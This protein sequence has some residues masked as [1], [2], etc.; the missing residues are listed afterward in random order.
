MRTNSPSPPV[1]HALLALGSAAPTQ[2][3]IA[4]AALVSRRTVTNVIS[5]LRRA[6]VL[7]DD[8]QPVLG[9]GLGLVVGIAIGRHSIRGAA[10]D[11]NG[12]LYHE[13]ETWNPGAPLT[14]LSPGK[15]I[16]DVCGVVRDVL[17]RAVDDQRL[18]QGGRCRLIGIAVAWPA[19][20]DRNARLAGK[21]FRNSAWIRRPRNANSP[22][23]LND[24]IANG[25]GTVVGPQ[26]CHSLNDSNAYAMSLAFDHARNR[27]HEGPDPQWRVL[28]TIRLGG[29]LGGATFTLGPHDS[30]RLGF[31]DGRLI[32]GTN[33]FAGEFGHVPIDRLAVE[34]RDRE[35]PFNDLADMSRVNHQCSCGAS[36]HLEGYA[37]GTALVSRLE[38]SG[39]TFDDADRRRA[40]GL[41]NEFADHLDEVQAHAMVDAGRLIGVGLAGPVVMLDPYEITI[42]GS[43]ATSHVRDGVLLERDR[44]RHAIGDRLA[45]H[46]LDGDAGAFAGL[47]GAALAVFRRHV[48]R[49]LDAVD[50]VDICESIPLI[51]GSFIEGLSQ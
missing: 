18:G 33:G 26:R 22:P 19:P 31:I 2:E 10:V 24:R 8:R 36:D 37:S 48:Y 17:S 13:H 47:R 4:D 44:W 45:V 16:G 41:R 42:A 6:S 46:H 34:A 21:V 35:N 49:Q 30:G 1:M 40:G 14:D 7:T 15:L 3:E 27:A 25:L 12:A 50:P 28:L 5:R 20:V 9:P 43:L 32:S 11:A 51:D 38:A 29:G 39:Y 23:T